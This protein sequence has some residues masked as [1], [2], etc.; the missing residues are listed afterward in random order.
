MKLLF[1]STFQDT[2][3]ELMEILS[4]ETVA[5]TGKRQIFPLNVEHLF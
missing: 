4:T 3:N 2:K 5:R 1:Q